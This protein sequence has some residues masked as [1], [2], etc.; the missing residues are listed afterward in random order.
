MCCCG[1]CPMEM[2]MCARKT[3]KI[4]SKL[5]NDESERASDSKKQS[6]KEEKT[7]TVHTNAF[8]AMALSCSF[9]SP[10]VVF[11]LSLSRF[12]LLSSVFLCRC[13]FAWPY[14]CNVKQKATSLKNKC[15]MDWFWIFFK[16]FW[17][18]NTRLVVMQIQF[19]K[20]HQRQTVDAVVNVY[21]RRKKKE[22]ER[23]RWKDG[24]GDAERRCRQRA[25]GK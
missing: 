17:D 11:S 24:S 23:R 22:L 20:W 9:F 3:V 2:K 1:G 25:A 21:V 4:T 13:C 5:V 15:L 6:G 19:S 18:L 16:C 7:R 8:A 10:I 12:F 14:K